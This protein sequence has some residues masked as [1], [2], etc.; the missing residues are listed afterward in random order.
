MSTMSASGVGT[1]STVMAVVRFRGSMASTA[2]VRPRVATVV[3]S[4]HAPTWTEVHPV[5]RTRR[6]TATAAPRAAH[7]RMVRTGTA[8]IIVTHAIA[9]S[10]R[11]IPGRGYPAYRAEEIIERAIQPILPVKEHTA[12][13]G[14]AVG[15][16][17]AVN[18]GRP[19]QGEEVLE[20]YFISTVILLGSEVKLIG[21]LVSQEVSTV[22]CFTIV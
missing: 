9:H 22:A 4:A 14:V 18:V 7:V 3:V 21:H 20:V 13:V 6:M 17:V 11:I 15:P 8:I 1:R 12:Q 5:V 10:Y 2:M 19:S 16:V